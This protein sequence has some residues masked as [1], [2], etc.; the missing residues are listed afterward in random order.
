MVLYNIT[1]KS[2]K[3]LLSAVDSLAIEIEKSEVNTPPSEYP[4]TTSFPSFTSFILVY[5]SL[6]ISL[7][8]KFPPDR[9]ETIING[10]LTCLL[11]NSPSMEIID[12]HIS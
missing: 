2:N 7:S 12:L 4:V 6:P 11:G 3:S 10:Y 9:G 1:T 5:N 8:I